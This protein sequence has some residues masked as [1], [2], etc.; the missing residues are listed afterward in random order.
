MRHGVHRVQPEVEQDLPDL[1]PLAEDP[2]VLRLVGEAVPDAALVHFGGA[3]FRDFLYQRGQREIFE[4][5]RRGLGEGQE[6]G[7]QVVDAGHF[8][9]H[10]A[11]Q[12]DFPR[13]DGEGRE[14]HFGGGLD[15]HEGVA[16]LVGEAEGYFAEHT[17]TLLPG[18]LDAL[19]PHDFQLPRHDVET[20]GQLGDLVVPP[21]GKLAVELSGGDV[22]RALVELA[23]GA[24]QPAGQHVPDPRREQGPE[25]EKA[26]EQHRARQP[27]PEGE[28]EG[29]GDEQRLDLAVF[30][31][32]HGDQGMRAGGV[33]GPV[34][35]G[36][37]DG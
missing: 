1:A 29:G 19:V 31:A 24:Y 9:N 20:G 5:Q 17:R 13:L 18:G 37:E 11:E 36:D 33:V 21:D 30:A 26:P 32:R 16:D 35:F 23:E 2:V 15:D 28:Q 14:H 4:F 34:G 27:A 8:F 12:A 6:L 3:Q 25:D 10:E 22:A 7:N